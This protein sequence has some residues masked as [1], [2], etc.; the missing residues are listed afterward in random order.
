MQLKTLQRYFPLCKQ[1]DSMS[2]YMC[3]F[4]KTSLDVQVFN[5]L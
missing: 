2:D 4:Y 1:T 5:D 3:N